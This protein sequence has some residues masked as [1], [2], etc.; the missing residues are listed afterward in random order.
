MS[1]TILV[2]TTTIGYAIGTFT[3]DAV[4]VVVDDAFIYVTVAVAVNGVFVD[5]NP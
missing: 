5:E 1:T 2:T 4:K 3:A